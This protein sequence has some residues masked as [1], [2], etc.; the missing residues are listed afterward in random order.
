MARRA[1]KKALKKPTKRRP[2]QI[3]SPKISPAKMEAMFKA[4]CQK[5]SILFVAKKC[6][7][8]PTT[9]RRYRE[10]DRWL[11]RIDEIQE[12]VKDAQDDTEVDR[13]KRHVAAGQ[14]LQEKAIEHLQAVGITSGK[15]AVNALVRG[16]RMEREA[17]GEAGETGKIILEVVERSAE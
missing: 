14:L 13:R 11:E 12:R 10:K 9:V 7:V 2:K 16:V 1:K 8:S 15:V 6:C 5:Q 17:M 3:R 4:Y